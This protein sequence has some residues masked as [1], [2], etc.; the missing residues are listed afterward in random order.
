MLIRGAHRARSAAQPHWKRLVGKSA[1]HPSARFEFGKCVGVEGEVQVERNGASCRTTFGDRVIA[2]TC[3]DARLQR[4]GEAFKHHAMTRRQGLYVGLRGSW[5]HF[6]CDGRAPERVAIVQISAADHPVKKSSATKQKDADDGQNNIRHG[7]ARSHSPEHAFP[8]NP[9][10]QQCVHRLRS[11]RRLARLI[12]HKS[13]IRG[14]IDCDPDRFP[15]LTNVHSVRRVPM[16]LTAN[17]PGMMAT[18]AALTSRNGTC[19]RSTARLAATPH[20]ADVVIT[21]RH[22]ATYERQSA[23]IT[24]R[25]NHDRCRPRVMTSG[26]I[27]HAIAV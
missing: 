2:P 8:G 12:T 11:G 1:Q 27:P 22:W 13:C 24:N 18:S 6:S 7:L 9:A 3:F 19:A 20:G 10:T 26:R 16:R 21:C 25:T 4:G 23:P 14:D 15:S 17:G 5:R